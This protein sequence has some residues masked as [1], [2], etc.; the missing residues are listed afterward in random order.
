M[1]KF[2]FSC[3]AFILSLLPSVSIAAPGSFED[4][5]YGFI[6]PLID[7]ATKILIGVA[8]LIFFYNIMINMWGEHSAEKT[9]K[10]IS[11]ITWGVLIIFVMSSIWGILYILRVTLMRGL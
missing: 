1:K 8:V 5:I 4:L 9:K 10:L 3:S 2:Y 11:T 7:Q 6:G